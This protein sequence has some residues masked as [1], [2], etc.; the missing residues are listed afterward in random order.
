MSF[1]Y[2]TIYKKD[3]KAVYTGAPNTATVLQQNGYKEIMY[4]DGSHVH[5]GSRSIQFIDG[6]TYMQ[7][8]KESNRV[9]GTKKKDL[10]LL[11]GSL[12][13]PESII[14]LEKD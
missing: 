2:Y 8:L 14:L 6:R 12:K 11:M 9:K 5:I 10:P 3:N 13:Y 1:H 7:H 4:I